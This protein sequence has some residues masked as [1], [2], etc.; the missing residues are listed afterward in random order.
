MTALLRHSAGGGQLSTWPA[1]M[2]VIARRVAR[3]NGEQGELGQDAQ[4]R[5]AVFVTNTTTGQTQT[6]DA[7]N[8]TPGLALAAGC[9]TTTS[10]ALS[11][12]AHSI[13]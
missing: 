6:L 7:R 1:D 13:T 5:H 8:P 12:V 11:R 4:W 2:R 9:I 3:A 10:Y